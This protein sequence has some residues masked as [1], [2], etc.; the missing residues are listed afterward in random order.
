MVRRSKDNCHLPMSCYDFEFEMVLEERE[1]CKEFREFCDQ[2]LHNGEIFSF[3]EN[4]KK[5]QTLKNIAN[6]HTLGKKIVT[7][8]VQPN[9]PYE[10]N[11]SG[12]VRRDILKRWNSFEKEQLEF[13]NKSSDKLNSSPQAPLD[14]FDRANISLVTELKQ[15]PFMLFIR[16][17]NLRKF[18]KKMEKSNPDLLARIAQVTKPP[19][20]KSLYNIF[21]SEYDLNRV[22]SVDIRALDALAMDIPHKWKVINEDKYNQTSI[23]ICRYALHNP[24]IQSKLIESIT[25][26]ESSDDTDSLNTASLDGSEEKE[27][28]RKE[29]KSMGKVVHKA[30]GLLN[31]SVE[32]VMKT[33]L[34]P[35]YRSYYDNSLSNTYQVD[36]IPT[37]MDSN[38]YSTS[39]TLEALPLP[40]PI[41]TRDFVTAN[42]VVKKQSDSSYYII[43]KSVVTDFAPVRKGTVRAEIFSGWILRPN[44]GNRSTRYTFVEWTD[45]K[46][47][48]LTAN[49]YSKVTKKRFNLL[50]ESLIRALESNSKL[51]FPEPSFSYGLYETLQEQIDKIKLQQLQNQLRALTV[52]DRRVKRIAY[53]SKY[54]RPLS[55]QELLQIGQISVRN[56][57]TRNITGMLLCAGGVFY[58]VV[59]GLPEDIE[60]VYNKILKDNRHNSVKL[61]KVEEGLLESERQFPNWSMNTVNLDDCDDYYSQFMK[62]LIAVVS[63]IEEIESTERE[64]ELIT[65]IFEVATR[66]LKNNVTPSSSQD[67]QYS[68]SGSTVT[69]ASTKGFSESDHGYDPDAVYLSE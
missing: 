36:Y 26:D 15:E 47:N 68:L 17:R 42:T 39:V 22:T 34:E 67:R 50:H 23:S 52:D 65:E 31:Y 63:H 56:N 16:S 40:W 57:Q 11:I 9:S 44:I 49:F 61:V 59:E 19:G 62:H 5:Y 33:L 69:I 18:V 58:Q 51:D 30:T 35:S 46:F 43:K 12:E 20:G 13:K 64:E 60:F 29:K 48:D 3:M 45:L 38:E 53:L 14:L 28:K 6:R 7:D 1:A 10:I 8:F 24:N 21:P 27:T 37:T 32:N 66:L 55:S 25:S 4:V 41:T 2:V 54:S